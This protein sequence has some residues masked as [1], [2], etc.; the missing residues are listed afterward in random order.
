MK[1]VDS[2]NDPLD[3]LNYSLETMLC[4]GNVV[5]KNANAASIPFTLHQ[6]RISEIRIYKERKKE[7]GKESYKKV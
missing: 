1:I 5:M 2:S 4:W 7:K 6:K 3:R